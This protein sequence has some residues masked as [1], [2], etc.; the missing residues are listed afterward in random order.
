M[1]PLAAGTVLVALERQDNTGA[2][3]IFMK[4]AADADGNF[5]FCP[6]PTGATVDVVAVGINGAGVAYNA[7]VAVG[8][9]GGT[10]LGAIPLTAETGASTGPATFQGFITASIGSTPATIDVA[11]SARQ[12]I[13]VGPGVT[14]PVTIPSEG[15]ST[16]TVT[17]QSNSI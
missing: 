13:N 3:V 17:T 16:P 15:N 12:T 4:T 1:S 9:P 8:V 5:N 2:D 10:N 7:T 11:V 14:R 6:L